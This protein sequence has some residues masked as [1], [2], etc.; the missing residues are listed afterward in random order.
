VTPEEHVMERALALGPPNREV[1]YV[2][3]RSMFRSGR[4]P[5]DSHIGSSNYVNPEEH[6]SFRAVA[7]VLPNARLW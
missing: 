6:V 3:L 4:W 7:L 1:I 2:T 5:L